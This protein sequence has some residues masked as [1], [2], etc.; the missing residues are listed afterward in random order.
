VAYSPKASWQNRLGRG[1]LLGAGPTDCRSA[2][3]S[4]F[5][6]GAGEKSASFAEAASRGL[7]S[8]AVLLD[9]IVDLLAVNEGLKAR[10]FD[11]GNV[12]ENIL[13]AIVGLDKSKSLG[14]VEPLHGSSRHMLIPCKVRYVF[15]SAIK[16]DR[17]ILDLNIDAAN[18]KIRKARIDMPA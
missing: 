4:G 15:G 5:C 2:A 10:S 16:P 1:S 11:S 7:A 9:L 8:A 3:P 17:F 18:T 14:A 13:P 12:H 6:L